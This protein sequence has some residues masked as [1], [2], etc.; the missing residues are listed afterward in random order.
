MYNWLD[1]SL[2]LLQRLISSAMKLSSFIP[3]LSSI[4]I[5]LSLNL[6]ATSSITTQNSNVQCNA[7][8]FGSG[9]ILASCVNAWR[10]IE[11]STKWTIYADRGKMTEKYV[12]LPFRYLSG[13]LQCFHRNRP[14]IPVPQH[15]RFVLG[16]ECYLPPPPCQQT[17]EPAPSTSS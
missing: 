1:P 10:K 17:T 2:K 12:P 11:P 13:K 6:P 16:V 9:L 7:Q 15:R 4:P 8:R 3:L 14:S 5:S